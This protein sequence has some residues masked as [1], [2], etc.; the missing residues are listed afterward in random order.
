MMIAAGAVFVAAFAV[1]NLL[2][3]NPSYFETAARLH[4]IY[5]GL[6]AVI[7]IWGLYTLLRHVLVKDLKI[8]NLNTANIIS[9]GAATCAAIISL[10]VSFCYINL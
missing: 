3:N 7:F 8:T 10:I 5:C 9:L 6:G 2:R 4:D 1:S